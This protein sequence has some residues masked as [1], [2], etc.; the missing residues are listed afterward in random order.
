MQPATFFALAVLASAV[1][2][3][4][5]LKA[6]FSSRLSSVARHMVQRDSQ[7][8]EIKPRDWFNGLSSDPGDSIND[9]RSVPPV[10]KAFAE[11]IQGGGEVANFEET[12]KLIDE[13]RHV[14][15]WTQQLRSLP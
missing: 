8:Y 1:V 14:R 2:S 13:V 15:A 10:C 11:R 9:P 4:F 7:G 12:I 5:A 3:A 6:P